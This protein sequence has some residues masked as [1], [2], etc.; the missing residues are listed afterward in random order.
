M[1]E[2]D[3]LAGLFEMA[4]EIPGDAET[5]PSAQIVEIQFDHIQCAHDVPII[6]I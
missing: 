3:C 4:G 6:A 2:I 5:E 1:G